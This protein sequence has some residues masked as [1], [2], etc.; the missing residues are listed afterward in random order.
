MK[1]ESLDRLKTHQ[2]ERNQA[3][4]KDGWRKGL[5]ELFNDKSL[6]NFIAQDDAFCSLYRPLPTSCSTICRMRKDVGSLG[7]AIPCRVIF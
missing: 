2:I 7:R 5:S 6:S 1:E 3:M 4:G